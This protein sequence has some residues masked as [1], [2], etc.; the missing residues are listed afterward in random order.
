MH[1]QDARGR[2]A[3]AS[4]RLDEERVSQPPHLAVDRAAEERPV[5]QGQRRH[6][7]AQP[8]PHELRD[9]E[10]EDELRNGQK[11]IR[12]AH[13]DLASPA[14]RVASI[15]ARGHADGDGK[16]YNSE[17]DF[18]RAARAHDHAGK[19]ITPETVGAEPEFRRGRLQPRHQI[20][21]ID[22]VQIGHDQ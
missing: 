17:R 20:A 5:G 9:S 6:G 1:E 2:R 15:K 4:L 21:V 12:Q 3:Q 16:R 13:D 8:A 19:D 11:H 7:A 10:C 18:E 14:V 22:P